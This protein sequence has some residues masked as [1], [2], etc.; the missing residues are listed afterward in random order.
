MFTTLAGARTNVMAKDITAM[1]TAKIDGD[2]R[3]ADAL[4]E[5][6]YDELRSL[7][8]GKLRRERAAH[9]LQPTALVHEA[10]MK[11]VDQERVSWQGKTHFYAVAAQAMQRILVDHARHGKRQKRGGGWQKVELD[12]ACIME[13]Q[14]ALDLLALEQAM[15]KMKALDPRQ[16]RVVELRL[17]GG[18]TA[19]ETAQMLDVSV[20]TVDRDWTMAQAWLRRELGQGGAD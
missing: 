1:L 9:T 2:R 8:D 15:E 11:L 19:D 20:R 10:Y 4:L 5:A 6:V 3:S 16:A 12:D 7:A 14:P 13:D 18:L 17:F